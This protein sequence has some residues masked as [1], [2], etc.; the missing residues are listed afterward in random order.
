MCEEANQLI[1]LSGGVCKLPLL[2]GF[3]HIDLV[4]R[5]VSCSTNK[6]NEEFGMESNEPERSAKKIGAE[7]LPAKRQILLND[8]N[9][10]DL[11]SPS[12]EVGWL[13]LFLVPDFHKAVLLLDP[14]TLDLLRQVSI[15]SCECQAIHKGNHG[16]VTR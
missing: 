9:K 14:W 13:C 10:K 5:D 7:F 2:E 1:T 15:F 4:Y 12:M 3:K 8:A 16:L 11:D 6:A